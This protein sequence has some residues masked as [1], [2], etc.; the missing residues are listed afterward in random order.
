[1]AAMNQSTCANV[2]TDVSV[3]GNKWSGYLAANQNV[4]VSHGIHFH[5]GKFDAAKLASNSRYV[6]LL[7]PMDAGYLNCVDVLNGKYQRQQ[8]DPFPFEPNN[9]I[10][11]SGVCAVAR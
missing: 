5:S 1:M 11:A 10:F 4:T 2:C 9:V 3:D 8:P 6:L 7:E